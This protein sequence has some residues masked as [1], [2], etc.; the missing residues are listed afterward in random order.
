[1]DG[2][3]ENP[4][5]R[6]RRNTDASLLGSRSSVPKPA[7]FASQPLL[8][9]FDLIGARKRVRSS[10]SASFGVT[11][12][13][14]S[15]TVSAAR[16]SRPGPRLGVV[17]GIL[18]VVQR[19]VLF[20]PQDDSSMSPRSAARRRSLSNSDAVSARPL[21]NFIAYSRRSCAQ[22]AWLTKWHGYSLLCVEYN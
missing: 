1:M 22:F 14:R 12:R 2:P 3:L 7:I 21:N 8:H 13:S 10:L 19:A 16:S 17:L 11:L 20:Q 5:A 15:D 18:A 4:A 9:H 6:S